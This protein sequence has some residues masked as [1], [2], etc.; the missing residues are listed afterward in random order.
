M[1]VKLAAGPVYKKRLW[2]ASRALSHRA[3]RVIAN[4]DSINIS[5]ILL[6]YIKGT[7]INDKV[8]GPGVY[9]CSNGNKCIG[10]WKNDMLG[11]NNI[12]S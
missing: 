12:Y 1:N 11:K 2:D 4:S 3:V 7:W 8:C 10:E 9:T 5:I 6:I